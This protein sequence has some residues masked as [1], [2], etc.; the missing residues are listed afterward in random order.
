MRFLILFTSIIFVGIFQIHA[1]QRSLVSNYLQNGMVINPAYTGSAGALS[2]S[3]SS[4][5]Q[6]QGVEN[7][8][9]TN[10]LA[11]HTPLP[12]RF[13]SSGLI[14]GYD[15]FGGNTTNDIFNTYSF[16][17]RIKKY[18]VSLGG[19]IGFSSI[20]TVSLENDDAFNNLQE[21]VPKTGFGIHVEHQK[22]YVGVSLPSIAI[23]SN[24]Q[25]LVA[26][27]VFYNQQ[28]YYGGYNWEISDQFVLKPSVYIRHLKGFGLQPD[29]NVM[30]T[31]FNRFTGGIS[32]RPTYAVIALVNLK[33]NPQLYVGYS[34]DYL[35]PGIS[36]LSTVSK[37]SHEIFVR[38]DF[39][40]LINDI[41]MKKFK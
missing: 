34:Y 9:L 6:W 29:I 24:K 36:T 5:L 31:A 18:S 21:F 19:L 23:A 2:L 40:Y 26:N 16:R 37:G 35:L 7:A 12:I 15:K 30:A 41:N 22:F 13:I 3:L 28:Y 20:N 33:I 39:M 17:V 14:V 8:P 27:D 38:Y 11:A 4:R 25:S 32:Y 10:V 1:Q